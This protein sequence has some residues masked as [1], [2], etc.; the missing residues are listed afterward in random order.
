MDSI[1]QSEGHPSCQFV[2]GD[3]KWCVEGLREGPVISEWKEG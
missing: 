3:L 2:F 1:I